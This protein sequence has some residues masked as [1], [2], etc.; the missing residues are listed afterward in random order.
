MSEVFSEVAQ[1]AE[2]AMR[3][4]VRKFSA[5]LMAREI[6]TEATTLCEG[7]QTLVPGRARESS[8]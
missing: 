7:F 4:V 8:D 2:F 1:V 3:S 6:P 5:E